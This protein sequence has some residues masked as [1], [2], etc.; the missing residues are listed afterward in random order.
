MG[1]GRLYV[2]QAF[3]LKMFASVGMKFWG[4]SVTGVKKK[5]I[6]SAE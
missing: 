1:G 4:V 5:K 3:K 2:N 6:I